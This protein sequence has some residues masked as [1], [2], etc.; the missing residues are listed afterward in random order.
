MSQFAR[1][2][3]LQFAAATAAVSAMPRRALALDYPNHPV[4][5]VIGFPPGGPTDIYGRLIGQWLSQRLGQP[6]VIENRPGAGSTIG[7]SEVVHSAPDG[8][9]LILV[10]TSAAISATFYSNLDFN[11][12]RDIAPVCGVT[13]VPMVMVVHPSVPAGTVPEFIAYAKANP[14][15]INMAS[16][17]NGTTPRLTGELF[18][19]M[20]GIDMAVVTYRENPIPDLLAGR[21]DVFFGSSESIEYIRAGKLRA[22]G[23]TSAQRSPALPDVPAIAEFVPG[24]QGGSWEALGAPKSTAPEIVEKLNAAM[25][26]GLAD[27]GLKARFADLGG[28]PLAGSAAELGKFI[29]EDIDKWGK[30]IK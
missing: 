8:Y 16:V 25:N 2:N 9:T 29:A 17:G 13:L 14:G 23:V 3:F 21:V 4:R 15:K 10:S 30:V 18:K 27:A 20:T 24:Y 11:L 6:F 22:L 12:V 1:R 5:L 26:A 28:T 19:M 7:V